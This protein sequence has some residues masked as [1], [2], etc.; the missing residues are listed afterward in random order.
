MKIE[1]LF[2]GYGRDFDAK[3]RDYVSDIIDFWLINK[4]SES[5]SSL[6]ASVE[7]IAIDDLPPE[8]NINLAD[9]Y[10]TETGTLLRSVKNYGLNGAIQFGAS[11]K[12]REIT[13][14]EVVRIADMLINN[15]DI[16]E[17]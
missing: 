9:D 15:G 14:I 12:I 11:N 1:S 17:Y 6:A 3:V 16:S 10:F 13:R 2:T 8:L 7:E 5:V 4:C